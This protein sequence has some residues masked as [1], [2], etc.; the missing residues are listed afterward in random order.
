MKVIFQADVKGSGKKGELKNVSDG[1]A[2]NFLL[3]KGLAIEAT[4][5]AM[6]EF[7]NKKEAIAHHKAE[8]VAL[9]EKNRE[10]IHGHAIKLAAKAGENGRL[11]GAVTAKEIAIE[12]KNV[13]GLEIDKRKITVPD[14]KELGSYPVEVKLHPGVTAQLTVA[15][16]PQE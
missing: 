1:Y 11:F 10:K 9:A 6:N 15:V 3:P 12:L 8:E 14:I 4:S 13:F 16:I 7:N 5:Q 2:R